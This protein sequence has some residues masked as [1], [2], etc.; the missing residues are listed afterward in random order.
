MFWFDGHAF[1]FVAVVWQALIEFWK[2]QAACLFFFP[3]EDYIFRLKE[4]I[5][6]L[7][8]IKAAFYQ[9]GQRVGDGLPRIFLPHL[10][11]SVGSRRLKGRGKALE[12]SFLPRFHT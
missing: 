7:A 10:Y 6:H 1:R 2:Q 11:P 9:Q 3:R 5:G 8:N 4:N 12:G